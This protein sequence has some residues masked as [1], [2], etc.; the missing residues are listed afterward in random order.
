MAVQVMQSPKL[1]ALVIGVSDYPDSPDGQTGSV[2]GPAISAARFAEWLRKTWA[3]P[4]VEL[5][6][7]KVLLSPTEF[8]ADTAYAAA[9][10]ADYTAEE[11]VAHRATSENVRK[12]VSAWARHC[13]KA[14]ADIAMLFVAGHGTE[15]LYRGSILLLE[16]HGAEGSGNFGNDLDLDFVRRAIGTMRAHANFIFVD[17]CRF[18]TDAQINAATI[19]A[20]QPIKLEGRTKT[21]RQDLKVF[22]GAA[23]DQSAY[24]LPD[25]L[26]LQNGTIFGKALMEALDGRR[27]AVDVDEVGNFCVSAN[28]LLEAIASGVKSTGY[29]GYARD[30]ITSTEGIG[31]SKDVPF[32]WP[33]RVPVEILI[34]LDPACEASEAE[35]VLMTVGRGGQGEYFRDLTL[36]PH[37]LTLRLDADKYRIHLNSVPPPPYKFYF[38]DDLVVM[39]YANHWKV[40]IR[41]VGQ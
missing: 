20:L 33:K 4:G 18:T 37:P 38:D 26:V 17:A 3:Y 36:V 5:G 28:R 40:R 24:T 13:D 41:Y 10:M 23:P 30:I 1:H 6:E 32:H 25:N 9:E 27:A 15:N 29:E 16:D 14:E 2:P 31:T 19:N 7:V 21:L 22:Y 11:R 39:P 35:A 34:E 12:A 8:E